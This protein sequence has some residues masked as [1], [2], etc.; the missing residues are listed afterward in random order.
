MGWDGGELMRPDEVFEMMGR[1]RPV[2]PSDVEPE[3][4]FIYV[5]QNVRSGSYQQLM[6]SHDRMGTRHLQ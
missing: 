1:R 2:L 3:V 4:K 6:R 5:P